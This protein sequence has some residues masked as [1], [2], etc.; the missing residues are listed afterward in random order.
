MAIRCLSFFNKV[1]PLSKSCCPP[2]PTPTPLSTP[3]SRCHLVLCYNFTGQVPFFLGN[4]F[5][6]GLSGGQRF[7]ERLCSRYVF[8]EKGILLL[9]A[10]GFIAGF[11][12]ALTQRALW[13][14]TKE[15]HQFGGEQFS[16]YSCRACILNKMRT[17]LHDISFHQLLTYLPKENRHFHLTHW[18]ERCFL[19]PDQ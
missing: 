1:I 13:H 9:G 8:L 11:S 6:P 14:W 2:F 10:G 7:T 4:L 3:T 18:K 19:L 5:H 15:A 17:W 12:V 16:L